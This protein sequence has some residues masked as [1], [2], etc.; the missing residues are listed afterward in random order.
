MSLEPLEQV[1]FAENP[2]PRCPVVL[3][4]DVSGSMAGRPIDELNQGLQEFARVLK[5]D[6]LASLRVE[7]AVIT[8]G[9]QVHALDVRGGN[10]AQIP[11]DAAQ[12]FVTVDQFTPP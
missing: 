8:F 11:F 5:D 7:V 6:R 9:G 12:A 3:L 4:L 10:Q 1:E 2:E